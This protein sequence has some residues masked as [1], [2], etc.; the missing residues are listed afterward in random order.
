MLSQG[1]AELCT[2][3]GSLKIHWY[4]TFNA[5]FHPQFTQ[6][7]SLL[8]VADSV[9]HQEKYIPSL[10]YFT[11][12]F[13]VD[14]TSGPTSCQSKGSSKIRPGCSRLYP[15]WSWK[16][17]RTKIAEPLRATYAPRPPCR[18]SRWLLGPPEAVTLQTRQPP[19]TSCCGASAPAPT[20]LVASSELAT[21]HG[22]LSCIWEAQN[23]IQ[24]MDTVLTSTV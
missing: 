22:C 7:H 23:W 17:L 14:G 24:G 12:S 6:S 21:V 16:A 5:L 15:V 3:T 4:F 19:V 18:Y 10:Q 9:S 8:F 20:I 13:R 2:V 11:E 1:F